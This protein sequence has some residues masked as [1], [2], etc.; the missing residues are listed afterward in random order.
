[1]HL[2]LT[3]GEAVCVIRDE[4]TGF[5]R[6]TLPDPTDPAQLEKASGRGLVLM[7]TFC[8][9]VNFNEAGNEVTLVKRM[10]DGPPD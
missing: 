5:D 3:P 7:R 10:A 9:E 1:V 8:D 6:A 4:G 2:K